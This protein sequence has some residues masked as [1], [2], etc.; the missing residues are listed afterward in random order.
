MLAIEPT[1][2]FIRVELHRDFVVDA[3]RSFVVIGSIDPHPPQVLCY[4][5]RIAPPVSQTKLHAQPAARGFSQH[6]IEKHELSFVPFV[7]FV[8][9]R[10]RARPIVEV[11]DWFYVIRATFT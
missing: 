2:N 1:R 11:L 6:L 7:R 3:E 5:S 4:A 9:K 10:M 8:S